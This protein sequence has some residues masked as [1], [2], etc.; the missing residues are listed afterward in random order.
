MFRYSI[1]IELAGG[2]WTAGWRSTLKK[3]RLLCKEYKSRRTRIYD[4]IK[5]RYFD[6][7]DGFWRN[8]LTG[9]AIN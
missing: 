6:S 9:N 8:T 4:K 2:S 3:A 7:N 1:E 5:H